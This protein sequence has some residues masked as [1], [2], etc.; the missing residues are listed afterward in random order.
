MQSQLQML[1]GCSN[2]TPVHCSSTLDQHLVYA[3]MSAL[4]RLTRL[5]CSAP[6]LQVEGGGDVVWCDSDGRS[7]S[8]LLIGPEGFDH[9]WQ[10]LLVLFNLSSEFLVEA[11]EQGV[12]ERLVALMTLGEWGGGGLGAGA[13]IESC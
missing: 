2:C 5:C 10:A 1:C 13:G 11:C 9:L 8:Q 6:L 4:T 12:V 7:S 3:D